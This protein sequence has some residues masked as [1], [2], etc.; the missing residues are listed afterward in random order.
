M[1]VLQILKS[2]YFKG[3]GFNPSPIARGGIPKEA[4]SILNPNVIGTPAHESFWNDQLW[5]IKNGM[6]T[7][8]L[9]IPGRYYYYMN[10]NLMATINGIITPDMVDLHLELTY[11]VDYVGS[12]GLNFICP[13]KRRGGISEYFQKAKIDYDVRFTN[14]AY[15]CGIAAG[16]DTYAQDFM[17]KWRAGDSLLPPE[18]RLKKLKDNDNE[19]IFGY[20]YKG[21][22][23]GM[24]DGGSK[25]SIYVRTFYKNPSLF[26]GLFL[27]TVLAE[28]CGEFEKLEQF[29]AHTRP[30][31]MDGSKQIGSMYLYGTGG[32][33]NKG[34]K[35]FKKI[36]EE[37]NRGQNNFVPFL[38]TAKRFHKPYY[39]G[40]TL[41]TPE[42]PHLLKEHKSFE[43]I[44]VED[45]KAAEEAIISER[46]EILKSKNQE[47]YQ[48]HLKDY[49]LTE[50][51][52]FRKTIVNVFDTEIM[53]DQADLISSNPLQYFRCRLEWIKDKNGGMEYPF[54][55]ELI[56][57]DS[58]DDDNSI[59]IHK[60]HIHPIDTHDNLFCAG[61]DSYDQDKA[62]TSKSKGAMC[63][64]I[65]RN[66]IGDKMQLA[67]VAVIC[68]R[69]KRKEMFYEMC[70]KLAIHFHLDTKSANS[71]L[72]DLANKLIFNYFIDRGYENV[73]A[74]RPKKYESPNS[75]QTHTYG[76]SLNNYSKPL[77]VGRMQT[78][79]YDNCKDTIWFPELINQLQNYDEVEI[80]SD[81]DLAD[82][83]GI[84][85]MQ[86]T[87][88]ELAPRD[89]KDF[90]NDDVFSLPEWTTDAN[91]NKVV[92]TSIIQSL[93]DKKEVERLKKI[94]EKR[95]LSLD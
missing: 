60:D 76:V 3:K 38:I 13:K 8:N 48:E 1:S 36:W 80:G 72:I 7:G 87:S 25:N 85:L 50:Q 31:V 46:Q 93:H 74:Y 21:D 37:A 39:G 62:K 95:F 56:I 75:E 10:F 42:T 6:Q 30:C 53:Q 26:K 52:V 88:S 27:N 63:V 51:D 45:I 78:A 92:K 22:D 15:Q 55:V 84:A 41:G 35:D 86:D 47:K 49:P 4:D 54:K 90:M 89:S 82:A 5:V 2:P 79:V 44:G 73:L 19:V 61:I 57:D 83:Y 71:V 16:Q 58:L 68:A 32:N 43:I 66:V 17:K 12:N 18:L 91:G 33:M 34:S 65:R 67:P 20:K 77:M 23:G 59:F 9:F 29:V 70:L 94:D 11:L 69:P 28:E 81:N 64:L 40:C 14:G 24:I